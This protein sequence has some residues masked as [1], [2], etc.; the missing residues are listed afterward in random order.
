MSFRVEAFKFGVCT[1]PTFGSAVVDMVTIPGPSGAVMVE[2]QL[3]GAGKRSLDGTMRM[4]RF[5]LKRKFVL[6]PI[7]Y[8][9]N[10]EYWSVIR[11]WKSYQGPWIFFDQSVANLLSSDQKLL[12]SWTTAA[13]VA[14]SPRADGGISVAAAG[15]VQ[16]GPSSGP[17]PAQLVPVTAGLQYTAGIGLCGTGGAVAGATWQASMTVSWYSLSSVLLSSSTATFTGAAPQQTFPYLN[18]SILAGRYWSTYTPPA[19]AAYAQLSVS[20]SGTTTIDVLD[21]SLITGPNDVGNAYTLVIITAIPETHHRPQTASLALT[22][23]EV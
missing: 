22:M 7:P 5:N 1:T 13:G 3:I 14:I 17:Q 21:P 18:G 23:E 20:N 6:S 19:G 16:M 8:A 11:Y 9:Q 2:D 15:V 12:I 10:T 4:D